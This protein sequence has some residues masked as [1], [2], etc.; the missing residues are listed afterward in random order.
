MGWGGIEW[1]HSNGQRLLRQSRMDWN[2]I[3][4]IHCRFSL[5]CRFLLLQTL[6]Y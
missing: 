2:F 1:I 6:K 3:E 4:W 5:Q